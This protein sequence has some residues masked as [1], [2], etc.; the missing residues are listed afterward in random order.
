MTGALEEFFKA[1]AHG[2]AARA[3]ALLDERGDL[4][5]AASPHAA[6]GRWTALHEAA[7]HGHVNVVRVLLARGADPNAREA[8]D[9]TTPLHWA[10][11]RGDLETVRSLLDAGV[12]VQGTGDAHALDVIG[13]AANVESSPIEPSRHAV[14]S[15][16][17]DRGAVHHVFS[18]IALG[19]LDAIRRV[20]AHDPRALDRRMSRFEQGQT[21]LHFAISRKRNDILDLLI[22]LGA[23]LEAVDARGN[24]RA[25]DGRRARRPRSHSASPQGWRGMAARKR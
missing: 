9:N 2:D 14:V 8:G 19:D 10:A 25:F 4:A 5:Y 6:H 11:A 23:D 1:C 20:V 16:L 22:A 18:A 7:R 17:L 24:D 3:D 12:D 13:W 15:L 21:P